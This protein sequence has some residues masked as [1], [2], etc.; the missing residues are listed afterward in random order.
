MHCMDNTLCGIALI[1]PRK[2]QYMVIK[3]TLHECDT[4]INMTHG[5]TGMTTITPTNK[6]VNNATIAI[7]K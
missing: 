6:A 7:S 3:H 5:E 2:V 4:T 1:L